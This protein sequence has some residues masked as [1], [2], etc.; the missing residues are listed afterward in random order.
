[1]PQDLSV[2]IIGG[3]GQLG[4]AM[5]TGWLESGVVEPGNLWISNRSGKASGFDDWSGVNFTA[6]NQELADACD[7]V[8]LSVP[9]ALT[10]NLKLSATS[11]LVLSVMAGVSH[12]KIRDLT[13]TGRAVRAMSSPAARQ[14][15][16]YSPWTAPG[17]LGDAD[18]L[19][20]QTLL[21]A[22]GASDEVPDE[23]QIEVFTVLTGPVPGFAALFADC[24]VQYA[25]TKNIAPDVAERAAKQLILSSGQLMSA[26][27]KAPDYFVREMIDYGG[28][29]A[30]GLE[31]LQELGISSLLAEGFEASLDRVRTIAAPD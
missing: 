24:L 22:I 29:T 12:Q 5:A 8:V 28:T 4:S 14:R 17:G 10:G 9:P 21:S 26:S 11:K 15:L 18:R 25:G 19:T 7:V 20:V 3:T 23:E 31:K 1:M 27:A 30:A 2:G 13:G 6:S 16:A